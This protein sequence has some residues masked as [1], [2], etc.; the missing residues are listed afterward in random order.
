MKKLNEMEM[1]NIKAGGIN[2][3]GWAI[4]VSI[5]SFSAGLLDGYTRPYK[6]R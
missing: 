6:C 5:L 1:K 3:I 2:A 4:I